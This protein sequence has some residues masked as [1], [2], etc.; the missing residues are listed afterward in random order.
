M[1]KGLVAYS[2]YLEF[3]DLN[4]IW[5][6]ETQYYGFQSRELSQSEKE[7]PLNKESF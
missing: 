7:V 3:K 5:K 4:P 1:T 2:K 6:K